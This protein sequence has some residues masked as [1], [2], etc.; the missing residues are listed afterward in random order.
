MKN[1]LK[2][3]SILCALSVSMT[4]LVGCGGSTKSAA[5]SSGGDGEQVNL[6]FSWWGGDARHKATLEV[7]DNYMKEH[8]NV[9]IEAEYGGVI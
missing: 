6:R 7:I 5:S 1:R 9:K 3:T 2:I 4:M 8:P